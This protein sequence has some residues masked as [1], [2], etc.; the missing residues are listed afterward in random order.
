MRRALLMLALVLGCGKT[1]QELAP[2]NCTA[3]HLCPDPLVCILENGTGV[4]REDQPC[5]LGGNDCHDTTRT[6]CALM[7]TGTQKASPQCVVQYA[8]SREGQDCAILFYASDTFQVGNGLNFPGEDRSCDNGLI[9]HNLPMLPS[10]QGQNYPAQCRRFCTS[11]ADCGGSAS[12]RCLDAFGKTV[13]SFPVA[14]AKRT[15]VC[16]PTCTLL[17]SGQCTPGTACQVGIDVSLAGGFGVCRV[18]GTSSPEGATC[19]EATPCVAGFACVPSGTAFACRKLCT[20]TAACKSSQT[21][22]TTA[23]PL[24]GGVGLCR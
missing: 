19:T 22:D 7:R 14:T 12:S 2:F 6:R 4:C 11:D 8:Q 13:T 24:E 18:P 10:V 5:T 9:C 15:G 1:Y 23:F 17:G 16:Y 21:C 3:D 20:A